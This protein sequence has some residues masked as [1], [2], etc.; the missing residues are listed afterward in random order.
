[1]ISKKLTLA[2]WV[3]WPAVAF[4]AVA[5]VFSALWATGGWRA[6]GI[7][8]LIPP[9]ED[10]YGQ[11]AVLDC[12]R[13]GVDVY[14]NNVCDPWRRPHVYSFLWL[15]LAPIG[16]TVHDTL[17]LGVPLVIV[18][19]AAAVAIAAPRRASE[20]VLTTL[21]LASPA[22]L[23]A[24][25]RAN[26]DLMVL[27]LLAGG[28]GWWLHGPPRWRWLAAV[29]VLLA[30]ALKIYPFAAL[31]ALAIAAW[32][33]RARLRFFGALTAVAAAWLLATSREILL[34]RSLIPAPT[35]R[36]A[37]GGEQL[38]IAVGWP[39]SPAMRFAVTVVTFALAVLIAWVLARRLPA[40]RAA[41]APT[42]RTWYL[43]GIAILAFCFVVTTNFDYRG[44]FFLLLLPA[45]F[46][47]WRDPA[48]GRW[49]VLCAVAFA[50]VLLAQWSEMA[51]QAAVDAGR[52]G[53]VQALLLTENALAWLAFVP[54]LAL[55]WACVGIGA[56][57]ALGKAPPGA[58]SDAGMMPATTMTGSTPR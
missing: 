20:A 10:L 31:C 18:A 22:L 53:L 45:L 19:G 14:Y 24:F 46:A 16:T 21:L 39:L 44:L 47:V 50:T 4:L 37:F 29:P 36:F 40:P 1:M 57:P 54:L 12:H 55:G 33:D 42:Q 35:G 56:S 11:L 26:N 3:L 30:T 49:R 38:F 28:L 23:L 17:R 9:F 58:M 15:W 51:V 43:A 5:A 41:L 8:P 2:P 34:L 13:R 27:I 25:E 6:W 48:S 52:P 32:G 7:P